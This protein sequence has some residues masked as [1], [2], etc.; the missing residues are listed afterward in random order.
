MSR[1]YVTVV[2]VSHDGARW[3]GETLRGLL[4]QS[5][6]PD[7]VVGV[8]NGSRDGSAD[9]LTEALGPG[10][11]RRLPRSTGFGEAVAEAL[12]DLPAVEDEW[13]WLLHDDCA[14]DWR[15]LE[16]LLYAAGQDRKA[17]VLGPK[18][19]DWL[20]R[21]RLLEIG[22]TVGL[23]GRR[24]T[25]LEPHEFDQGQHDG[26]REALSVST[27]GM[28]IRRDVWEAAG[29]LDP[30]F[31]LFRDDL[32]LCWRV[33]NAG[34]RVLAVTDAVAWHAEAAARRR[35]RITVSGDHPRR[36]D[37]RN[38]IFVVMANLPFRTMLWALVRNVLGS[39]VR[40]S[41]FLVGKQPANALDELVALGSILI[42]PL[43]LL[44]ARRARRAGRKKGY[45]RVR[46]L[47]TPRGS[48]LRRLV[49]MVR[50][51]LS[52]D[53]PVES[54]GRHHHAAAPGKPEDPDELPPEDRGAVKRF[55]G[56]PGVLLV[57]ALTLVTLV[58]SRSLLGGDRL[59][60]G[61][62][63]PVTGSAA[64][65]WAFYTGGSAGW[66]P[67]YVA[68]LAALSLP[69]FGQTGPVVSAL[70]L[71]AVPLAG[72]SAYLA[73]RRLTTLPDL[74]PFL[75][76][77]K[78]PP[79]GRPSS[80]DRS[81]AAD[82]PSGRDPFSSSGRSAI[83]DAFSGRHP[84]SPW[85]RSSVGDGSSG[86]DFA[87][88]SGR[89]PTGDGSSGPDFISSSGRSPAAEGSSGFDLASPSDRAL[90]ASGSS[91]RG[92]SSTLD[93]TPAAGRPSG[94]EPGRRRRGRRG[95]AVDTG[96][97]EQVEGSAA[98]SPAGRRAG[99]ATASG[100][101]GMAADSAV[102]WGEGAVTRT[103]V[104]VRVWVA[105]TYALLPVVTGA[106]AA[107]R[108][109]TAV[110]HVLLPAY[111]VLGG[112]LLFG[113]PRRSR[114]AAWGLG[115]LLAVGTAFVPLVYVL[116]AVLGGA[117]AW[118]LRRARPG[119]LTSAG[120]ALAV[121]V[122][123]LLPW[124]VDQALDPGRLLLEAGLHGPAL[125][126]ARLGPESLL[127]LNPGGP[128]VPPFWVTAGLVAAGLA[129][130]LARRRRRAVAAGWAAAL[131]AML[132]AVVIAR[133][134]VSGAAAWPG[135]PLALAA[136]ALIVL[137]GL[138]A[139]G[140]AALVAAGG[141]RRMAAV[142]VAAVAI[143]TPLLAAGHW[144]VQ[145]VRGPL[146]SDVPDPTPPLAAIHARPGERILL[147]NGSE[148]TLLPGRA[149]LLGEAELPA[150]PEA[151]ARV[152]TAAEGLVG[153]R[154]G[155][156]AATLAQQGVAVVA[157]APPVPAG[158]AETLDSQPSL[159]RM[160][161]SEAGGLWRVAETVTPVQPPPAH[162]LH[163]PWLWLQGAMVLAVLLLAAP[164]RRD[165]ATD[166]EPSQPSPVLAGAR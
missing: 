35:R 163:T 65:L 148:F 89:S 127:A 143:S 67:P 82:G 23:T 130:L 55:L 128:G 141:V 26:T 104:A 60:G 44:R 161:L 125:S 111:A 124:L 70:L 42:H 138:S 59:G 78:H 9:L 53:R 150:D 153:G 31:P 121:P 113:D 68:V 11:V 95:A 40:T 17:A 119:V 116:V 100:A 91:R 118:L 36:L 62:L 152:R 47:L 106:V 19:R 15:A 126:D 147:V 139:P 69:A 144:V 93:V 34:H 33:R 103:G 30:F 80:S 154:G 72:A 110:V 20:D 27:A 24:D 112:H 73:T 75:R 155:T 45:A 164:G 115:L 157:I 162:F 77:S 51:F 61:A 1:P 14:P 156:D 101:A 131:F 86:P 79:T 135:V 88:S 25:G 6:R 56:R 5:R 97:G 159:Q 71:G 105:A 43:R 21:R 64:D 87:S 63:V 29:G 98:A 136:A 158:L 3:L 10:N 37:R 149:P 2:V 117:A 8:D 166:P 66:A 134:T 120:I 146:R 132:V 13:V 41:L 58:A 142:L 90:A 38:A 57:L 123:L 151:R 54:A 52:G 74:P 129:A 108:L 28:L 50:G 114:R 16:A 22:V 133:I 122:A 39:F 12:S 94:A 145:G 84:V 85:G 76:R 81:P 165:P 49:D 160:S 46:L 99:R 92:L 83:A 18:L 137:A 96:T 107:G 102:G 7:R 4:G 32:D 48:G 109:G 140:L